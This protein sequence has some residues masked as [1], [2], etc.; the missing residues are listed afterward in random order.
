MIE[1]YNRTSYS[2]FIIEI[3]HLKGRE[4]KEA[5]RF[6]LVG[7]YPETPEEKNIFIEK[8]GNKK[9]SYLVFV[10]T[11]T[12]N[13]MLPLSSLFLINFFS[14]KSG[15]AVYV[16]DEWIEYVIIEDGCLLKT[17]VK[18]RADTELLDHLEDVFGPDADVVEVFCHDRDVSVFSGSVGGRRHVL[19]II[20]SELKNVDV[21]SFSLNRNLSPVVKRRRI[22][23]VAAGILVIAGFVI[24]LHQ[25]Q[26]RENKKRIQDRM[27][28]EESER[29]N[30]ER[31][32]NEQILAELQA[33]YQE[34]TSQKTPSPFEMAI[35]I[36]E[37]LEAN[38]RVLSATFN[39]GFFQIDG[40][41]GN[42][43]VLLQNFEK[44]R[45]SAG[46]R[47]HQVHPSSSRD[48][49]TLSG[50]ILPYIEQVNQE[51]PME[52]QILQLEELIEAEKNRLAELD[53][54][55]SQFGDTIASLLI[56]WGCRITSYQYLSGEDAIEIEYSL[57]GTSNAFFSFLH[58]T[59]RHAAWK[60]HMVQIRNLFPR[61][62]LDIVFRI[63]TNNGSPEKG[64]LA[65]EAIK[66]PEPFP[67]DRITKNY[68]TRS[69]HPASVGAPAPEAVR[70]VTIP[71]EKIERAGWLEYIGMV[72][73]NSGEPMAYV[74]DTRTGEILKL[75]AAENNNMR[76]IAVDS[77]NIRAYIDGRIYE[78]S[79]K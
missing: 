46:V 22:G 8:N 47:L 14:K 70:P 4:L 17:T 30:A 15:K 39:Q 73:D 53:S 20:D 6:K 69:I 55:P 62:N 23:A 50:T 19:H 36:S 7:M 77:G 38:T 10:L 33:R 18:K 54:M 52:E 43:L 61:N 3:P 72:S 78:I 71:S 11:K 58:E 49:F 48:T 65:A 79:K 66:I 68:Y 45:L 40:T 24:F 64:G 60:I 35:A 25:Y 12:E 51:L 27:E 63:K 57:Q 5:V 44:H 59:S 56:K 28:Q 9:W 75:S 29:L 34:L 2:V 16:E 26:A 37:C 13:R 1:I 41:T 76:Y 32:K 21:H 74:K 42:S 67:M 31:R